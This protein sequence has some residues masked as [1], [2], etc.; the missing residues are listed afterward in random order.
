MIWYFYKDDG[1]T[2]A[3]GQ[4][5]ESTCSKRYL[6]KCPY[7]KRKEM[8]AKVK[9]SGRRNVEITPLIDDQIDEIITWE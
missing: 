2:G 1:P 9:N 8:E 3:C 6:I 4:T 5:V 7:D